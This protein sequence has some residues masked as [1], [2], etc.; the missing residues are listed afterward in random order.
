MPAIFELKINELGITRGTIW[1]WVS[2][3][4]SSAS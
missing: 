1:R 4:E 3:T 2:P